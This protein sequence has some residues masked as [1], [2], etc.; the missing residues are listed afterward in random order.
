MV[1]QCQ[2]LE[3]DSSR[4]ANF[5]ISRTT[6]AQTWNDLPVIHIDV[7]DNI[8]PPQRK[9][10]TMIWYIYEHF[11]HDY[12]WFIRADD[13]VYL[14]T[15]RLAAFL[16]R[17]DSYEEIVICQSG[18]GRKEDVGRLGFE[19]DDNFCLGEPGVIMSWSLL[20]KVRPQMI[21]CLKGVASTQEDTEV[22]RC[23]THYAGVRCPWAYEVRNC[24][25][26]L[27]I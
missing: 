13:D 10:L 4:T 8:Y 6:N 15:D 21:Y 27:T 24:Y 26:V 5:F 22:G 7:E 19:K 16:E 11:V 1:R 25:L 18:T 3:S 2:T 12:E 23:I 9:A 20:V 14:K 17:L